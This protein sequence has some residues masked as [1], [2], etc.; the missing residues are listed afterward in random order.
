MNLGS[1]MATTLITRLLGVVLATTIGCAP[2]KA[3]PRVESTKARVGSRV[4]F[5]VLEPDAKSS[6]PR[7]QAP[8]PADLSLREVTCPAPSAVVEV[9]FTTDGRVARSRVSRSSGIQ[10]LD[11]GCMLATNSCVDGQSSQQASLEC[12]VQCE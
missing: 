10:A 9:V 5:R 2:P 1:D 12:S 6:G 11:L 7:L 8:C 4:V 3:K